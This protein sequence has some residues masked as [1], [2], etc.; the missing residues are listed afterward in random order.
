MVN[1]TFLTPDE[2]TICDFIYFLLRRSDHYCIMNVGVSFVLA[3]APASLS[4]KYRARIAQ[5]S[6]KSYVILATFC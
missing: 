6:C 5:K 4:R 1:S 3:R 2:T